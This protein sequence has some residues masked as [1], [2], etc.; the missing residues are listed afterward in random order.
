MRTSPPTRLPHD[1]YEQ[2]AAEA[3]RS[4]RTT[5]QQIAHWA[6]IGRELE[7]SPAVNHRAIVRVL[8][9]DA[10]Y[11][12]LS[13]REQALVRADWAEQEMAT[14]EGL[15]Y[16]EQFA[17]AGDSWSEADADGTTSVRSAKPADA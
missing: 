13:E 3:Q 2:A 6:R 4:S 12:T 16:A 10:D 7:Q 8:A 11:D 1:V 15:N 5:P 9:G 17:S 14:R